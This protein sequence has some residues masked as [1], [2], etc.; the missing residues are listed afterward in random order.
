MAIPNHPMRKYKGTQKGKDMM[1]AVRSHRTT[2][3]AHP[4]T[5][6]PRGQDLGESPAEVSAEAK[7]QT[8]SSG[9]A[10]K[11]ATKKLSRSAYANAH[12]RMNRK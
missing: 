11:Q 5:V 9:H 12:S 10:K 8:D 2:A 4:G 3:Q 7:A 1:A 6:N